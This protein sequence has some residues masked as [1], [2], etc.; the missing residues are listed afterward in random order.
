MLASLLNNRIM[1][2]PWDKSLLNELS[3]SGFYDQGREGKIGR[4]DGLLFMI[5][6]NFSR[7]KCSE[8]FKN[9]TK[10]WGPWSFHWHQET[11]SANSCLIS[12]LHFEILCRIP[13]IG[14]TDV[15]GL[16]S[17]HSLFLLICEHLFT[18]LHL[19]EGQK[20]HISFQGHWEINFSNPLPFGNNSFI[21]PR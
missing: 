1:K 15:Q 16:W 21:H 11:Q 2:Q 17:Q 3:Y 20:A 7:W 12:A 19:V 9:S 10:D 4:M 13:F 5:K 14:M 6:E 18:C 8:R